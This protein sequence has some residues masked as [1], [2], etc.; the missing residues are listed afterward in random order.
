MTS[1]TFAGIDESCEYTLQNLAELVDNVD[2]DIEIAILFSHSR[3]GRYPRYPS[4]Y[5]LYKFAYEYTGYKSIHLCGTVNE[6]VLLR[7]QYINLLDKFDSIQFNTKNK[8]LTTHENILKVTDKFRYKGRI[9]HPISSFDN[10]VLDNCCGL[11]DNSVGRGI[12]QELPETLPKTV[13]EPYRYGFAGGINQ[14]TLK[15][16]YMKARQ[17]GLGW[18]DMESCC[19]DEYDSFEIEELVDILGSIS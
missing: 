10:P 19:R 16:T 6:D 2:I 5:F 1:V 13:K 9:I 18:I 14:N 3:A 7:Q 12:Q 15:D 11:L 4:E 17:L 8:S